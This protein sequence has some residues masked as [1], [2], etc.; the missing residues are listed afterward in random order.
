MKEPPKKLSSLPP[1]IPQKFKNEFEK[2]KKRS[3][4]PLARA[5]PVGSVVTMA[6]PQACTLDV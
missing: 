1:H 6:A 5:A 4:S 3:P 2:K